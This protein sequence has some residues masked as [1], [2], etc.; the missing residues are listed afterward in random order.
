M[1]DVPAPRIPTQFTE[2]VVMPVWDRREFQDPQDGH[3]VTQEEFRH[4]DGSPSQIPRLV[5]DGPP[6]PGPHRCP[7]T[8]SGVCA[9]RPGQEPLTDTPCKDTCGW[10]PGA[11]QHDRA[12]DDAPERDEEAAAAVPAAA[13]P[14]PDHAPPV[15]I[16]AGTFAIYD[17]GGG[18][19][20]GVVQLADGTVIKRHVGAATVR[21]AEKLMGGNSPLAGLLGGLL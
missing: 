19:F 11:E 4:L 14:P 20:A 16:L 9:V 1:T 8:T 3:P 6:Q 15:P 10:Y 5:D 2:P 21:M 7:Q 12:P 13:P 17:D 18:G